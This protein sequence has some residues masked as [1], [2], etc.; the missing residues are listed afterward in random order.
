MES[1]RRECQMEKL[2]SR[3]GEALWKVGPR[4]LYGRAERFLWNGKQDREAFN[5]IDHFALE[6]YPLMLEHSILPHVVPVSA[7]ELAV[8]RTWG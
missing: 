8:G 3:D 4:R 7:F 1:K 6:T 2:K 5:T